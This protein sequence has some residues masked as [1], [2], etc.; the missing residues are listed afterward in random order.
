M[1][2]CIGDENDTRGRCSHD[3]LQCNIATVT[4]GILNIINCS[5]V[6]ACSHLRSFKRACHAEREGTPPK[7]LFPHGS[8]Q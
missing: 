6:V 3:V 1:Q 2:P 5:C 8:C 7:Q 4:A